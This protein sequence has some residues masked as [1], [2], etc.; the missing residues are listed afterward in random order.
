MLKRW[1]L[2]LRPKTF[3]NYLKCGNFWWI[4][5]IHFVLH[6]LFISCLEM[7]GKT[8]ARRTRKDQ[9]VCFVDVLQEFD[10]D[11]VCVDEFFWELLGAWGWRSLQNSSLRLWSKF[12]DYTFLE[13]PL[14]VLMLWSEKL[15]SIWK[16]TTRYQ[17][18]NI[19][20]KCY[21][22]QIH[23]RHPAVRDY[24]EFFRK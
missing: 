10:M 23:I 17:S 13:T 18:R 21:P 12:W 9:S 24:Q 6:K 1:L 16:N 7:K 15:R 11:K 5:S 14:S 3:R 22:C 2:K 19:Y 8:E 20:I 4:S